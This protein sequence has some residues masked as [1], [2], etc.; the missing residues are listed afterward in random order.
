MSRAIRQLETIGLL[1]AARRGMTAQALAAR[2]EVSARTVYRDIALLQASGVPI[3][4]AAGVGYV[5]RPGFDLPPL[6]FNADEAEAIRVALALLPR[7]G[8]AG[9][10]AAAES[11]AHKL[12]AGTGAPL[13]ASGWHEIP[14]GVDPQVLRR[15]IRDARVLRLTYRDEAG[16]ESTRAV[17]PLDLTYFVEAQVLGAWCRL[18]GAIRHFRLDRMVSASLTGARFTE[19]RAACLRALRRNRNESVANAL[20][21][22]PATRVRRDP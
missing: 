6:H 7:T 18:R 8:D 14:S 9:L 5:L 22:P 21:G 20:D 1:R 11:V 3:E 15:A 19:E 12:G 16:L 10:I 17:L 4:G 2:L 13:S